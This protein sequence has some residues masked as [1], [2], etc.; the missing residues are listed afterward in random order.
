M[1]LRRCS[2]PG[3]STS[4]A[5]P[6]RRAGAEVLALTTPSQSA[7]SSS[8]AAQI[9]ASF[10]VPGLAPS[11]PVSKPGTPAFISPTQLARGLQFARFWTVATEDGDSRF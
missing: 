11:P 7:Q 2:N 8:L 1:K 9:A 5:L 10:T 3:V 4:P 6:T